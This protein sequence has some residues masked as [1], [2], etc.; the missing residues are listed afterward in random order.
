MIR[1]IELHGAFAKAAGASTF[2]Y[3]CDT[4]KQLY[5]FLRNITPELDLLLRNR[6]VG[7]VTSQPDNSELESIPPGLSFGEKPKLHVASSTD[8]A[9]WII[10]YL[11]EALIM[12]VVS[13][14]VTRLT[15]SSVNTN[16]NGPGG[17]RSSMFNGPV[18]STD[19]GGPI[20]IVYGKKFLI[21]STIMAADESYAVT[22]SLGFYDFFWEAF[23]E[24]D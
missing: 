12:A 14:V 3:D 18:N 9:Y 16:P 15:M 2:R 17:P 7:L 5:A 4:P 13:Y 24:E 19:Q 23:F 20:P 6:K 21:G 1:E 11:I 22:E 8:G 10:P